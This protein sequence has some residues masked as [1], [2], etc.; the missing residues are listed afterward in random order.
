MSLTVVEHKN[1]VSILSKKW[2]SYQNYKRYT[3]EEVKNKYDKLVEYKILKSNSKCNR[4][5]MVFIK[6]RWNLFR[7]E[8]Y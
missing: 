6:K 4:V 7:N 2:G 3:L 5:E 8:Y 1:F